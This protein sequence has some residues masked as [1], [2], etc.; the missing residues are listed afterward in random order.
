MVDPSDKVA[1]DLI[2][3]K[4]TPTGIIQSREHRVP[5]NSRSYRTLILAP[6]SFFVVYGCHVRTLEA[7]RLLQRFGH[8][9]TIV[10]R[11]QRQPECGTWTSGTHSPLAAR[12]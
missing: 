11:C 8:R 12:L 5:V 9:V 2:S 6:T 7:A 1:I 4:T 10:H 3:T